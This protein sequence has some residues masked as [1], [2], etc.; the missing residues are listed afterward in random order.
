MRRR[1]SSYGPV[2]PVTLLSLVVLITLVLSGGFHP[3]TATT[4]LAQANCQTFPDTGKTVCGRFLQY[5]NEHGGLA[6]QGLPISDLLGEISASDGN[7]YTVQYFE[8]AVFEY[9]PENPAPYA[10]LLGQLGRRALAKEG[11]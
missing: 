5:W 3:A 7:T 1:L 9:H 8:R 4:A 6:Q 10:V 2:L 11:H